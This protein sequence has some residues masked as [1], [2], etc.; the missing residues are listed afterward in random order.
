MKKVLILTFLFC[1]CNCHAQKKNHPKPSSNQ[2]KAFSLLKMGYD[3]YQKQNYNNA[4][5]LL[6]QAIEMDENLGYAYFIRGEAKEYSN[7]FQEGIDDINKAIFLEPIWAEYYDTRGLLIEKQNPTQALADYTTAI[8]IELSNK[9]KSKSTLGNYYE[10]RASL[11]LDI[12][13]YGGSLEDC[14]KA[15]L[16]FPDLYLTYS[17]RAEINLK[18]DNYND[19]YNDCNT[20]I[21]L[22]PAGNDF[23]PYYFRGLAEIKLNR[24]ENACDDFN[25]AKQLS[26]D[27]KVKS[28]I[29]QYCN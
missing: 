14:N 28:A 25:K 10:H 2:T 27:Y 6:D 8:K 13:D 7:R 17:L 23:Y 18:N 1:Y 26:G 24:F 20:A 9:L 19:A 4:I 21:K 22:N 5:D 15:I 11:K 3:E 12:L 16:Y 29:R